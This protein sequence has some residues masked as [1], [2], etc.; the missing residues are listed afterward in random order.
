ML[1][2][3]ATKQSLAEVKH[4]KR[5]LDHKRGGSFQFTLGFGFASPVRLDTAS[6]FILGDQGSD[7]MR[8]MGHVQHNQMFIDGSIYADGYKSWHAP[9]P[10]NYAFEQIEI[11]TDDV[12]GRVGLQTLG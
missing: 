1:E 7:T 12:A 11:M 3:S 4:P 2:G 5:P 8:Q 6:R 9:Q 10:C